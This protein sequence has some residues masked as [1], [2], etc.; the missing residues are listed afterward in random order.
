MILSEEEDVQEVSV[1]TSRKQTAFGGELQFTVPKSSL[2]DSS[3]FFSPGY[4][5]PPLCPGALEQAMQ[6][7]TSGSAIAFSYYKSHVCFHCELT[8]ILLIFLHCLLLTL[9][10]LFLFYRLFGS[11]SPPST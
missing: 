2:A 1:G 10:F 7:G 6:A 4:T 9:M 11:F 8:S 5:L 3:S